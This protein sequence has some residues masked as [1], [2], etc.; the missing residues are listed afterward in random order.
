[1]WGRGDAGAGHA[2]EAGAAWVRMRDA[3]WLGDCLVAAVDSID[4][5]IIYMEIQVRVLQRFVE[6]HFCDGRGGCT[7]G[8][9]VEMD[10]LAGL[11]PFF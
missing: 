7:G 1:M 3:G 8:H 5:Q 11:S 2:R 9:V 6:N 4:V 10:D